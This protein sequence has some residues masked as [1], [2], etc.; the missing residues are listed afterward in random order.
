MK[1]YTIIFMVTTSIVVLVCNPTLAANEISSVKGEIEATLKAVRDETL[2]RTSYLKYF[3][4]DY[5]GVQYGKSQTRK[6]LEKAKDKVDEL[7]KIYDSASFSGK[8]TDLNIHPVWSKN[9]STLA[10][11][12]ILKFFNA[13]EY[14]E[15]ARD[16]LL[17]IDL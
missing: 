11:S 7:L 2:D 17:V 9:S 14:R 16:R 1:V 5:S 6:D 13:D 4:S 10:A 3:A 8:T 15:G 12:K